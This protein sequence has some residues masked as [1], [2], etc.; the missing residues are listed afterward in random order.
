MLNI[1]LKHTMHAVLIT[2]KN[3]MYVQLN[4]QKGGRVNDYMLSTLC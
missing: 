2:K 3:I 1:R 4:R